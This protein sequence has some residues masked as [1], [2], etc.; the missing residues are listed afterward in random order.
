MSNEF[1]VLIR[2][3]MIVTGAG[4]ARADL[5]IRGEKVAEIAPNLDSGH[6][7]RTID[8]TG[9]YVLPGIID[10]HTHPVYL[11]DLGGIS[12]TGPTAA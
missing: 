9:K 1:D 4:I 8:A 12:V 10:V 2:G 7:R 11:D 3:G 6:A 5:G